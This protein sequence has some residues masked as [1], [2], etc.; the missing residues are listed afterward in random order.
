MNKKIKL[1]A[2]SAIAVLMFNCKAKPDDENTTENR[3]ESAEEKVT[4][5]WVSLF[6]GK[7]L[8]GW[9]P[10]I[11]GYDYGDNIHNTFRVE[12][13]VIKV[14]YD[15]YNSEFKDAFGHLF[16]K[17]PFSNYRLKM[18]YRFTGDQIKDGPGWAT[19][20]SGVMVHCEDPKKMAKD[21]K[22]P[23]SIEVQMLGGITEGQAR[24]TGNLCTPGTNVVMDGELVTA[25]CNNSTSD[26]YY[27]EQWVNLEVEVH[28][29]SLIIHKINDKEVL[30]YSKPQYGGGDMDDYNAEFKEKIGQP[31]KGGY[32]SL[33]SESH[34]VE[35]RNI[36]LL[37]LE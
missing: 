23:L 25:H 17:T 13:G 20:N 27:G 7:D 2:V 6:N 26:T 30:R 8:E 28:S 14:S 33:Q 19:R 37:E 4:E 29:D 34:P 36:E 35:F 24:S 31:I 3:T 9:T 12:D 16:Y 22:F 18:Q 11:R 21:Q 32:F 10:K 5:N 1:I 15:G